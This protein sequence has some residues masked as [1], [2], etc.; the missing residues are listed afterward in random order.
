MGKS[1]RNEQVQIGKD[2]HANGEPYDD[3]DEIYTEERV[4]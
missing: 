2:I 4:S 3:L 1:T